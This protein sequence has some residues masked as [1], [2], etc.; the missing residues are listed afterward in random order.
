M[1][2]RTFASFTF[3]LFAVLGQVSAEEDLAKR[4]DG[5]LD[6]TVPPAALTWV[7]EP[8]DVWRLERFLFDDEHGLLLG[9]GPAQLVLGR[10]E[11]SDTGRSAIWAAVFPDEPGEIG[12]AYAGKGEHFTAIFLRFHPSLVGELF[13]ASS[14][15]GPGDPMTLVRARE[16]Y[17][18]K[19][20]NSWHRGG[21]PVVPLPQNLVLDVDTVEGPRRFYSVDRNKQEVVCLDALRNQPLALPDGPALEHPTLVFDSVWQAFDLEYP[22]FGMRPGVDWKALS[23]RYRPLAARATNAREMAGVLSLLLAPL[24]DLHTSVQYEDVSW[25]TWQRFRPQNANWKAIRSRLTDVAEAPDFY[26]GLLPENLGY[27]VFW[28]LGDPDMA[29]TFDAHLERFKDTR[30]LILDLRFNGGGDETLARTVAGRFTEE[31][32]V[33]SLH[34]FRNGP[35]H[36]DLGP[37]QER[38]FTPRGPWTYD[39]PVVVLQGRATMSSAESFVMMLAQCPN[40]VTMG[41]PT[42]GSSGNPRVLELEGGLR[43]R[44]P[45]WI[46]Y[47][48]DGHAIDT[49]GLPPEVP[50]DIFDPKNAGI[51]DT[52]LNRAMA[53]FAK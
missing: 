20:A 42:A 1:I 21:M 5:T 44:L 49:V 4:Y 53:Q 23:Q 24:E 35:G 22:M 10:H 13:P 7:S 2:R 38:Q 15:A 50:Y 31:E 30:G 43:V 33:Y 11:D 25:D 52:L 37:L 29:A 46:C 34:R 14:V 28:K 6:A 36:G 40:V 26:S 19:V 51:G 3:A 18:H 9:C 48:A 41:A 17:R 45:R 16:Q 32:T 39:K 8:S 27:F 47:D 12:Q